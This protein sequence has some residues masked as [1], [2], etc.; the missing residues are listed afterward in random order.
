MGSLSILLSRSLCESCASFARTKLQREKNSCIVKLQGIHRAP[1]ETTNR[2]TRISLRLSGWKWAMQARW[3]PEM[4]SAGE[5]YFAW[6]GLRR[7]LHSNVLMFRFSHSF[8][9]LPIG[10]SSKTSSTRK[11]PLNFKPL[12]YFAS[13]KS[14][15]INQPAASSS[16]EAPPPY[17]PDRA[18]SCSSDPIKLLLQMAAKMT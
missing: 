7:R 1:G 17:A 2:L 18:R 8:V 4:L 10:N 9:V 13:K 14:S 3:S 16:N 5:A 12:K 6:L 15:P 11:M